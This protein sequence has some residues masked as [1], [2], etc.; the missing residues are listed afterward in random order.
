MLAW[1]NLVWKRFHVRLASRAIL[2]VQVTELSRAGKKLAFTGRSP[3]EWAVELAGS[4]T[5]DRQKD[6]RRVD[7]RRA[8]VAGGGGRTAVRR[9]GIL[10]S[11]SGTEP[12]AARCAGGQFICSLSGGL[13]V[14]QRLGGAGA[15]HGEV[16]SEDRLLRHSPPVREELR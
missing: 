8:G 10:F 15:G 14:G 13:A 9:L 5:A 4:L 3:A 16:L 11:G 2:P 1:I 7:A 6:D 12:V